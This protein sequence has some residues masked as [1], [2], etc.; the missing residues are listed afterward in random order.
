MNMD[1]Q[2]ELFDR[3]DEHVCPF[4]KRHDSKNVCVLDKY[5]TLL[6]EIQRSVDYLQNQTWKMVLQL[7]PYND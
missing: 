4:A 6:K 3:S 5:V 2:T 1:D 7:K